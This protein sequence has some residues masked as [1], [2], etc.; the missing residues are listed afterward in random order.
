MV[1]DEHALYLM[2]VPAIG[3]VS[4]NLG[5]LS[6]GWGL[7]ETAYVRPKLDYVWKFGLNGG[8]R[9]HASDALGPHPS[10]IRPWAYSAYIH[11]YIPH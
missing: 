1:N 3:I 11:I 10:A 4:L 2:T 9:T 7:M 6:A 8:H 5:R